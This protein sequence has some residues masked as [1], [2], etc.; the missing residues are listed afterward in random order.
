MI[1]SKL[2]ILGPTWEIPATA[3]RVAYHPATLI[4]RHRPTV[5]LIALQGVWCQVAHLQLCEVAL[6]V[7]K[8]HPEREWE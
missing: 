8:R 1:R 5:P 6:E 3:S 4:D 2:K 7:F